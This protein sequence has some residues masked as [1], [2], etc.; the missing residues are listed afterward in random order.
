MDELNMEQNENS[1]VLIVR[2]LSGEANQNEI[3]LLKDW[4]AQAP[5]H[6]AYFDS[7]ESTYYST[8]STER[9]FDAGAAWELV[10]GQMQSNGRIIEWASWRTW[11]AASVV[12]MLGLASWFFIFNEDKMAYVS[13]NQRLEQVIPNGTRLTLDVA[14]SANYAEDDHTAWIELTGDGYFEV[15]DS[16]AKKFFVKTQE[17]LIKDIGTSFY[18]RNRPE[19]DTMYFSVDEGSIIC[20]AGGTDSLLLTKGERGYYCR[21]ARKLGRRIQPANPNEASFATGLLVFDQSSMRDVV[22]QL[23]SYYQTSIQVEDLTM[24]DCS[25]SVE[26]NQQPIEEVLEIIGITL[27]WQYERSGQGWILRGNPCHQN[28]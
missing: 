17:V 18:V 26:F 10:Q 20:F 24:L 4:I 14:S 25:I 1:D 9:S 5:A 12:I 7:F 16:S 19:E 27:G 21:S 13:G 15:A 8:P 11:A 28:L 23:Q 22:H 6:Q 2:F 3:K